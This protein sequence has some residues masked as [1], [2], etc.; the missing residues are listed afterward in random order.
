MGIT[1][2]S[3]GHI[4]IFNT[5][6]Y[7]GYAYQP[8][9][10][11][12]GNWPTRLTPIVFVGTDNYDHTEN[13]ISNKSSGKSNL[14]KEHTPD[15]TQIRAECSGSRNVE[16]KDKSKSYKFTI[17]AL[18]KNGEKYDF[19]SA[20]YNKLEYIYDD[21][22]LSVDASKHS[23]KLLSD[24]VERLYIKY[25]DLM[26]EIAVV[27]AYLD[28]SAPVDFYPEVET[29]TFYFKK[30]RKQPAFIA[31]SARNEYLMLWGN[32]SSIT[33]A[34]SKDYPAALANWSQ[35]VELSGWD[36]NIISVNSSGQVTP[37]GVG[38]TVI[39]AK[40]MGFEATIKVVVLD[41]G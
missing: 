19:S 24:S 5:Q 21:T 29:L 11:D 25:N 32:K 3:S 14:D 33:D 8:T 9:G 13:V 30:E 40:Y 35:K 22:K 31:K 10:F 4:D 16:V 41:M 26:C 2:D 36:E 7:I 27:P 34:N 18:G 20:D 12:W 37:K 39:V 15:V 6:Q 28:N 1:G 38:E 17:A 23:V